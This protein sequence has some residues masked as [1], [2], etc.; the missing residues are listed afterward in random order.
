MNPQTFTQIEQVKNE[1]SDLFDEME[2]DGSAEK[3]R[4]AEKLAA[5]AQ[6]SPAFQKLS[7][8]YNLYK[9]QPTLTPQQLLDA[10]SAQGLLQ[11]AQN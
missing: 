5:E 8:E 1:I 2:R 3:L 7:K 9:V 11:Q 4:Q 6:Q 10:A